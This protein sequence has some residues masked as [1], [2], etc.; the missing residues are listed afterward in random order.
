MAAEPGL[1]PK[2]LVTTSIPCL[3]LKTTGLAM[4]KQLQ[5]AAQPGQA[6]CFEHLSE[7]METDLPASEGNVINLP[8]SL[9]LPFH[10]PGAQ[11][12]LASHSWLHRIRKGLFK[13]ER[14]AL[15]GFPGDQRPGL[16]KF[17]EVRK[18]RAPSKQQNPSL[19]R[20][21]VPSSA[22]TLT[23]CGQEAQKLAPVLSQP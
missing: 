4:V 19:P 20:P 12:F 5:T 6:S 14:A 1:C 17:L 11:A 2:T 8:R 16:E 23:P 13:P 3:E 21:L 9:P 18:A 22:D 10:Q 15:L 7:R